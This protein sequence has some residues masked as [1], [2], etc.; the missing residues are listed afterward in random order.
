MV[1]GS[2]SYTPMPQV[3]TGRVISNHGHELIKQKLSVTVRKKH[4]V[5]F[6]VFI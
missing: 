5:H 2:D 4:S 3:L 1:P 6:E